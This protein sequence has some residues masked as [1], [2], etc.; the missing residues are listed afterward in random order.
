LHG[1][2]HKYYINVSNIST[3]RNSKLCLES[4]I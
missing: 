1:D 2:V 4:L 3:V